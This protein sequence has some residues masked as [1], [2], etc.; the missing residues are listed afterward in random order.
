MSVVTGPEK[1]SVSVTDDHGCQQHATIVATAV[2]CND[3]LLGT[4]ATDSPLLRVSR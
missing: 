2:N 3:H 1:Y 4:S